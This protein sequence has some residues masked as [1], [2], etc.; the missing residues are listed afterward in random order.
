MVASFDD[1]KDDKGGLDQLIESGEELETFQP[2]G[3][4][5]DRE[6]DEDYDDDDGKSDSEL[7]LRVRQKPDKEVVAS[8]SVSEIIAADEKRLDLEYEEN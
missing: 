8:V 7:D 4:G 5:L 1:K 3:F 2:N 6:F